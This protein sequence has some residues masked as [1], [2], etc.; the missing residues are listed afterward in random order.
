MILYK[1]IPWF[2]ETATAKEI[3]EKS[4]TEYTSNE[5]WEK[6]ASDFQ[7]AIEMLPES[8]NDIGRPNKYTAMAYLA[9]TKLYQAYEQDEEHNV[10]NIN[11]SLLEEVVNLVSEIETD[12]PFSLEPD[13]A[14]PFLWEMENGPEA[15]WQIQRS[16]DDGTTT[17][18]VDFSA[19]L[20]APM[21]E[22]FGCCWFHIPSQ[23]LV[24]CF[25]TDADGLPL[26]NA[27]NESNFVPE[28]DQVDP[29]L[30]HSVAMVG[31]PWKYTPDLIYEIDWARQPEI[32]G[33]YSSLKE[34]V[35]PDCPCLQSITPFIA[36][37]K[38]TIL[39]RY[40][41][42]LLWKAEALIELNRPLEALPIINQIR[43]RAANSTNL[44]VDIDGN[45]LSDY[46]VQPYTGTNWSQDFARKALHWERRL[47]LALEGHRFFD[48]VRW[49]IAKETL[50]SYLSIE[51]TRREYL[52]DAVF[53]KN[54]HEYLP[55]PQQQIDLSNE[56]YEQNPGYN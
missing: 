22:E 53:E 23:N 18:N 31:H 3:N 4:N 36:S 45:P 55:I 7:S 30:D 29:R 32:Y 48:L 13:F 20:N 10:I 27:Y 26:F 54:K 47:E 43:Q 49:G 56:L 39:I 17:G 52:Q 42:V 11:E 40:S 2:D 51:Q 46:N 34:S 16:Y 41:D 1:N 33:E 44:L 25:K 28:T 38:N 50:D 21:S 15:V 5:I 37:S 6:I 19:M 35:A 12:G 14:N 9:K 8:Q 24:N